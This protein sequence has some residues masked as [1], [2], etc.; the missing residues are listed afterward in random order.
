MALGKPEEAK[1]VKGAAKG[2]NNQTKSKLDKSLQ[3]LIG[4][5]YDMKLIEQSIV[6]IGY[7]PKQLPLGQLDKETINEG[8]KYLTMIE[9]V[10]NGKQKGDLS[11]LSSK[12]YTFIPHV[13]KGKM[14]DH[15]IDT[16]QKLTEKQDLVQ[17]L[18]GIKIAHSYSK[19]ED[20]KSGAAK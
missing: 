8:F 14:S 15:I 13:I 5:I 17:N 7:D 11:E 2:D 3:D 4:F 19:E 20:K 1:E 16:M 9:K 12:F 10:L 18:I 6:K